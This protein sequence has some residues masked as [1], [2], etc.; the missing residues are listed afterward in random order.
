MTFPEGSIENELHFSVLLNEVIEALSP[1]VGD[2]I[3]DGT[4]GAGGYSRAIL[5]KNVSMLW[6]IDRDPSVMCAAN[7]LKDEF[8][9]N[10]K[11][12]KGC[13]SDMENLL[14][15]ETDDFVDGIVLDIGVSSMQ[16]DQA[17]RGFSFIKDGPL[18]M[19]MGDQGPTAADVVNEK[20]EAELADIIYQ[21]GEERA[22]RRVA[23]AIVEARSVK[24]FTRTLEL[25]KIV[26]KAVGGPRYKKGKRQIHSAT[27]TFQALRIYVNDELG[28]LHRG[29]IAAEKI[30][31]PGGRLCVVTFHSL[32]DR[33][34]KN[35]FKSRSGDISQ[36]SRHKPTSDTQVQNP[37]FSMIFRGGKK[38]SEEEIEGN[39]RSRSAKLRAAVR[40]LAAPWN[41]EMAA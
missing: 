5:E 34:V 11:L 3:I 31:A 33:M 28:E 22:S 30:L 12:L 20:E 41:K 4:F 29:L 1:K 21:F 38:A 17:E 35:F 8:P 26:E 9:E 24:E 13:F 10:F 39:I 32:E 19:R 23:R 27:R 7:Q 16:L 36:V 25:A 18:D 37:T 15:Q 14:R 2:K 40:T 6:G